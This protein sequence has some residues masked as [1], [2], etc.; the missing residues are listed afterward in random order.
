M[1]VAPGVRV[2]PG[3]QLVSRPSVVADQAA[4]A[5]H[6]RSLVLDR[7]RQAGPTSRTALVAGTTLTKATISVIVDGLVRDGLAREVGQAAVT[8]PGRP[9]R[10]VEYVASAHLVA[11][12][13]LG[14]SRTHV[15]LA[16]GAGRVL[17]ERR[18]PT[19]ST[20][21]E[22]ALE[23]IAHTIETLVDRSDCASTLQSVALC[24]PGHVDADTGVCHHAP[25]LGW[26]DVP[27]A[28]VLTERLGA[29]VHVVNDAQ[30]ALVAERT[31]GAGA[32]VDDLVLL[33]AGDG[34]SAAVLSRGELI[35]GA[36]G[37]SGEIGHCPVAGVTARCGCGR[38]GCLETVASSRAVVAAVRASLS[39][40]EPSCLQPRRRVS[41][42]QI[43]D[44]A[45]QHDP[46]A[47]RAVQAAG[48]HLGRACGVLVNVVNPRVVVLAGE[49][50]R[51]GEVLVDA[52]R[53]A[54]EEVAMAESWRAVELRQAAFADDAEVT[55][56]LSMALD[57]L[58]LLA[59]GSSASA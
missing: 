44:A 21:A 58:D 12:V 27:V 9:A 31:R 52:V 25:N 4:M 43:L 14:V 15:L 50:C 42:T 3:E 59:T 49:L 23:D 57:R 36:T 38:R 40:G 45:R 29:E 11:A 28:A 56:A 1:A 47:E 20:R 6:N 7:L 5:R 51:G 53:R 19:P 26:H 34:V 54:A 35:P 24:L 46:V 2:P 10:L 30:A 48:H 18:M 37:A 22:E 32:G 17:D 8:G 16:D 41:V 33:Y 39:S 13:H 55:G